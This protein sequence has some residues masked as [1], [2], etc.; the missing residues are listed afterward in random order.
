[1]Y[2]KDKSIPLV[3]LKD[4]MIIIPWCHKKHGLS[5]EMF[6]IIITK[7]FIMVVFEYFE[8]IGGLQLSV[9]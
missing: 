7:L 5:L 6:D 2:F 8:S 9:V 3:L 4:K 1:M